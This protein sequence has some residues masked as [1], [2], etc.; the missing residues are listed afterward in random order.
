VKTAVLLP[1]LSVGALVALQELATRYE[2]E[3]AVRV[4]SE[5]KLDLESRMQMKRDGQP[6]EGRGGGNSTS[7]DTRKTTHVDRWV[8]CADGKPSKVRRSFEA[9]Q[10]E[11]EFSF[12]DNSQTLSLESPFDG[13]TV[14]IDADGSELSHKVV[15]GSDPGQEAVEKLRPELALDA[16]LP[17]KGVEEGASWELEGPAIARALGF[18]VADVLFKRPEPEGGGGGGGPGGGRGGGR[19]GMRGGGMGGL[20]TLT[21]AKWSGKATYKGESEKDGVRCGVIALE[22]EADGKSDG[23]MGTSSSEAKLSGDLYFALEARRPVA[24]E[25]E[26]TL[27]SEMDSEREREGVVTEM[28]RESDGTIKLTC[29]VAET[30]FKE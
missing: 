29:S 12:G 4:V 21:E 24:L 27:R 14:E 18:D 10:G 1:F 7:S 20:R 26:G 22:L 8:A 28:H 15:E 23:D 3:H 25:L 30:A 13:V 17:T 19:G 9:A 2:A 5:M 16:L 11:V 6:V